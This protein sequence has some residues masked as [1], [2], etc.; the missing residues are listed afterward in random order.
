MWFKQVHQWCSSPDLRT[1]F[2]TG[3]PT[4]LTSCSLLRRRFWDS[5]RGLEETSAALQTRPTTGAEWM[6]SPQPL[7][8]KFPPLPFRLLSQ[9]RRITWSWSLAAGSPLAAPHRCWP[10]VWGT[11]GR[12]PGCRK[13]GYV[14]TSTIWLSEGMA[15]ILCLLPREHRQE[16][17]LLLVPKDLHDILLK[18]Q[19]EAVLVGASTKNRC[20]EGL[21]RES[22][23][24]GCINQWTCIPAASV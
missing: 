6:R 22:P 7:S 14:C 24:K 19:R 4:L 13:R 2:S 1:S 21:C 20:S 18:T 9:H 5:L 12:R 3:A 15:P 8:Q 16:P 10:A 23:L 11:P 17:E